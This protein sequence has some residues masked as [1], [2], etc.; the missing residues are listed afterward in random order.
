MLRGEDAASGAGVACILEKLAGPQETDQ[1]R[2]SG[3]QPRSWRAGPLILGLM[4]PQRGSDIG[5]G[6]VAEARLQLEAV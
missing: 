6:H 1:I 4:I 5:Q 3:T 2:A